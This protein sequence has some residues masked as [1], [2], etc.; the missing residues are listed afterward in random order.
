VLKTEERK[1]KR[2]EIIYYPVSNMRLYVFLRR[3]C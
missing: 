2:D 1:V 3:V